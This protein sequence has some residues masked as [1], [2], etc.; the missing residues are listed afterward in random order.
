MN[1]NAFY[2]N[3][4]KTEYILKIHITEAIVFLTTKFLLCGEGRLLDK[5]RWWWKSELSY[6]T[7][8]ASR[9]RILSFF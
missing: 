9:G 6:A 4:K 5:S 2:T 8:N 3:I 1:E 7:V